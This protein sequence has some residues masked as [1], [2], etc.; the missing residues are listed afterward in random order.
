[1]G[2]EHDPGSA[3]IPLPDALDSLVVADAFD[4]TCRGRNGM[5]IGWLEPNDTD[6]HLWDVHLLPGR[7]YPP[8][9]ESRGD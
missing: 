4:L 6:Q 8:R 9:H 2:A 7:E 5:L 1:L 3:S